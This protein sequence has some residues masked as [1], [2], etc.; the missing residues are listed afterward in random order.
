MTIDVE[1]LQA[2]NE[3]LKQRIAALEHQ[4]ASGKP[5]EGAAIPYQDVFEQLPIPVSIFRTDGVLADINAQNLANLRTSRDAIVG[6]FNIFEDK[7]AETKGYDEY[8]RQAVAGDVVTMPPSTYNTKQADLEGREQDTLIWAESTYF[9]IPDAQGN[10]AYVGMVNADITER[11]HAEQ[12]LRR[13]QTLLQSVIDNSPSIIYAKDRAWRLILVNRPFANLLHREPQEIVGKN[14]YDLF[15]AESIDAIRANDEQVIAQGQPITHEETLRQEDGEHTYLSTK[16]PLYDDKGHIYGMGGITTDITERKRLEQELH[17]REERLRLV[18]EG[19]SDGA[20]DA[21]LMTGEAYYSPQYATM[22]GYAHAELAPI[23]DTWVGNIHPDDAPMAQQM[24]QDYL[25]GRI[26]SYE[27]EHRLRCKSGAWLWVLA[28]GKVTRRNEQGQPARMTGT[29]SNIARRK[30]AEERLHEAQQ[31]LKLVLDNLPQAVFWKDRHLNYLG[32]NRRF[33]NDAGL[34]SVEDIVGKSDYDM[35]WAATLAEPYRAD[36]Q[37]T[38]EQNAPKLNYEEA[39][40]LSDGSPA[41]VRTSKI[42]LHDSDGNVFAVLGMYED[43]TAYRHMLHQLQTFQALVE[44]APDGV[45]VVE[46]ANNTIQ[47]TN[48]A[49]RSMLNYGDEIIGMHGYELLALTTEEF[50]AVNQSVQE[51]G[52]WQG[53]LPCKRKDGSTVQTQQSIFLTYDQRGNPQTLAVIARDMTEQQ[54]QE[55]ERAILQQQIIEAQRA[56]LRELSTP[57]IPLSHTVVLMP[58]IGSIDSGR[59]QLVMETLLE[60]IAAH[61]ADTAILDI[62]GVSVVDTQVANALIQAAQAVRLLGA[63]VVLTGIGPTM[64]QTLVHL[65]ADLRSIVTRGSLQS[66]IVEALHQTISTAPGGQHGS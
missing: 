11:M 29:V 23:V 5:E 55:E 63:Q 39:L 28:R 61:Q 66:A 22:L 50:Q 16:F 14:D 32:C 30:Q 10:V 6:T 44:N 41:W 17:E 24:F 59:A 26:P 65:G 15:P 52:M 40:V 25:A 49:Y 18:L 37:Y 45:C 31:M 2:E 27:C 33:A 47:Y 62:T 19:S 42:P 56:A 21:N 9:P 7:E 20:W 4:I 3:A 35:P 46:P 12:I 48:P 13:S 36:D 1:A 64:A 38:M 34:E 43:I 58:L 54:R 60:G 51:K 57:L 53:P 8:F